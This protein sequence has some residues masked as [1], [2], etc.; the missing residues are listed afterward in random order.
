MPKITPEVEQQV[1]R[2]YHDKMSSSIIAKQLGIGVATCNKILHQNNIV[3]RSCRSN[4]GDRILELHRDGNNI[5]QIARILRAGKNTVK[6]ILRENNISTARKRIYKIDESFLDC[7]DSEQ[8]AYFLGWMWSDG[9]VSERDNAF[10]IEL[11][12]ADGPILE[13]LAGFFSK[14]QLVK[15]YKN[16]KYRCGWRAVLS[17]YSKKL[18]ARLIE[19][20]CM[21]NKTFSLKFPE[22]LDESLQH[23]FVRGVFDGDGCLYVNK[24]NS[25]LFIV[26]AAYDLLTG[27][28]RIFPARSVL[29]KQNNIYSLSVRSY[30]NLSQVL[31][32]IYND[33]N[34]FLQRK[35]E[36]AIEFE[37]QYDCY[38]QRLVGSN[39]EKEPSVG[40][41]TRP[42]TAHL[43]TEKT[44]KLCS[45][46]KSVE[47]FRK[48][49]N[50]DRVSFEAYCR[51]C[52]REYNRRSCRERY[53]RN[54]D[55]WVKEY[56]QK[57]Y[58]RIKE[59]NSKWR[60]ENKVKQISARHE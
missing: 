22:W 47:Q 21:P 27:I 60:K 8:K 1:C 28:S 58:D 55:G 17:I 2:L 54:K 44:C 3:M 11:A 23:H 16:V 20:G 34:V 51:E 49:V 59:Y 10:T 42:R 43:A 31:S 35:R 5:N 26:G 29:S 40:R 37:K 45:T 15:Y 24:G 57:N 6:R 36:K 56:R 32:F 7:I 50:G 13:T 38:K 25:G 46:V 9:T 39:Q 14:D 4:K 41:R 53:E 33:A 18:K 12:G 48:R 19:L 52:E 30:K